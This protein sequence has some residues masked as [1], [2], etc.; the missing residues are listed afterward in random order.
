MRT[1]AQNGPEARGRCDVPGRR[2][3]ARMATVGGPPWQIP[4]AMLSAAAVAQVVGTALLIGVAPDL[5]RGLFYGPGQLAAAHVFGLAFLSLAVMGALLQLVPVVLRRQV[6]GA[7]AAIVVGV[8]FG[9]G[10]WAMAV[11]FWL[12][13]DLAI[14]TGGTLVVGAGGAFVALLARTLWRAAR[15]GTLGAPGAGLAA[16][17]AW[18]TVLL[19]LGAVMA[20]NLVSPFLA[21]DR[22]RLLALHLTVALLGWIG[23]TILAVSLKLAPMFA[24]AHGRR[25]R[26][27][28]AAVV[29]WHAGVV[30]IALGFLLGNRALASAGT[31]LLAAAAVAA[32]AFVVDVARARRRR[33]EAPLVHLA[34]GV[35]SSL[36]ACAVALHAW[37][38]HGDPLRAGIL[39][40]LLLMIGL[41][42]GVTSGHLFKVVPMLIWTGRY[43]HL[44]GT[45]GAP[46]LADL[47]PAPLAHVEQAAFVAGL[48]LLSAG[49]WVGAP[50]VA[51]AGATLLAV[52]ALATAAAVG[53]SLLGTAGRSPASARTR[54]PL[55]PTIA[56]VPDRKA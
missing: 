51:V 37:W 6:A 48:A 36:T 18:F 55:P 25:E 52:A 43:A 50:P 7:T 29:L 32:G 45:P 10:S 27:G 8:M 53:T 39:V 34:V 47:Y 2:S 30:P 54:S 41:G 4:T 35:L 49:A 12:D 13:R 46:R 56:P 17:A 33:I 16:S 31:V 3:S 14:A 26:L 40:G 21:I 20:A 1:G 42:N 22:T 19:A 24:L 9:G 5:A 23:G 15:Q 11:G 44:A 38:L 28:P